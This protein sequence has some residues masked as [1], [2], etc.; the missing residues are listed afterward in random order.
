MRKKKQNYKWE[1]TSFNTNRL[2]SQNHIKKPIFNSIKWT[3]SSVEAWNQDAYFKSHLQASKSKQVIRT[4]TTCLILLV[5]WTSILFHSIMITINPW[6][7]SRTDAAFKLFQPW[8]L[9]AHSLSPV[10][11]KTQNPTLRIQ[12]AKKKN[13]KAR[14]LHNIDK[15]A[16]VMRKVKSMFELTAEATQQFLSLEEM[17]HLV[18]TS[19]ENP[20]TMQRTLQTNTHAPQQWLLVLW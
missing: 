17:F 2:P 3:W 20:R 6:V 5:T 14:I 12:P 19:Q 1:R 16:W 4:R 15:N 13:T 11:G 18:S 9:L 7:F 8:D 10:T